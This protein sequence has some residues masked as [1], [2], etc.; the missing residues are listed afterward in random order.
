LWLDSAGEPI[1]DTRSLTVEEPGASSGIVET[2]GGCPGSDSAVVALDQECPTVTATADRSIPCSAPTMTILAVIL[3]ERSPYACAAPTARLTP[4]LC[5]GCG[6]YEFRW[7]NECGDLLGTD[8]TLTVQRPGTYTIRAVG[9]NGCS[10]FDRVRVHSGI[11][12]AAVDAGP[13]RSLKCDRPSVDIEATVTG[14][15]PPY[16]FQWRD[17]CGE[18]VGVSA[19]LTVTGPGEYTVIVTTADGCVSSDVVRVVGAD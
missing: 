13:D 7:T 16:I 11:D 8:L 1:A 19:T 3:G 15:T 17:A 14:G 9:S 6:P 4:P 5:S 2:L 10:A 12:P 18:L